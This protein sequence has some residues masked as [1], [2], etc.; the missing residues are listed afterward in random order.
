MIRRTAL[1]ALATAALAAGATTSEAGLA[2]RSAVPH[3]LAPHACGRTPHRRPAIRH[4][5]VVVL[6]N[7]PFPKIIGHAPFITSLARRCGLATSIRSASSKVSASLVRAAN[8]AG[9]K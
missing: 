7:H 3:L 9:S 6:E 1:A 4:V 2:D 8:A 5:V